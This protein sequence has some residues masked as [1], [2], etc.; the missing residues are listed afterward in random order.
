MPSHDTPR[1]ILL[2]D[3]DHERAGLLTSSLAAAG[4][5]EVTVFPD[6]TLLSERVEELRPAMVLIDV[7]SPSRDTLEQLTTL[8]DQAPRP[9]IMFSQDRDL[10]AIEAAIQSGVSAYVTEG[11][12]LAHVQPAL[13]V[14]Q[15]TFATLESLRRELSQAKLNLDERKIIERAKGKLMARQGINEE[16][17]YRSLRKTA[18]NKKMRLVDV[19]RAITGIT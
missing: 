16:A 7:E 4:Y 12:D 6:A 19:A 18:M 8:R 2:I 1:R 5:D 9:V 11:I 15:A 3:P 14:A 10:A 17:A 13:A